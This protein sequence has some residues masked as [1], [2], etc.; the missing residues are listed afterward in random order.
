[1]EKAPA[2]SS[3]CDDEFD[4]ECKGGRNFI[5]QCQAEMRSALRWK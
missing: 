4:K 2:F 1:M 5:K 3:F